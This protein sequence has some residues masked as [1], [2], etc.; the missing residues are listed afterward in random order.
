MN[1]LT[2]LVFFSDRFH[3]NF[4]VQEWSRK[5]ITNLMLSNFH[6]KD[7]QE[8]QDGSKK[9]KNEEFTIIW[10]S[11]IQQCGNI[12][13]FTSLILREIKFGTLK[14]SQIMSF[15][16]F[17]RLWSILSKLISHKI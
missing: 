6:S 2:E 3:E 7:C 17:W 1:A 12:G 14:A 5:G 13:F 16:Q 8:C 9:W 4:S 10:Y 11:G 15:W